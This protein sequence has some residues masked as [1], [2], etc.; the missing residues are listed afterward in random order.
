MDLAHM[1]AAA[2]GAL[3]GDDS[4][5]AEV[6]AEGEDS[7][8]SEARASEG[9]DS[10]PLEAEVRASEGGDSVPLEAIREVRALESEGL[11]PQE[12]DDFLNRELRKIHYRN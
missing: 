9:E 2:P 7:A 1:E 5:V 10:A 6:A 12:G 11:A 4:A 8:P 3:E